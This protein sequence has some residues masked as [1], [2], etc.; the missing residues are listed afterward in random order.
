MQKIEIGG[1]RERG[2][3]GKHRLYTFTVGICAT[4]RPPPLQPL[5]E[6]VLSSEV[7]GSL[8]NKVVLVAS[9]CTDD[10]LRIARR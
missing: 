2:Q 1:S 4:G 8:L 5:L 7:P 10:T 6:T 3:A 9:D